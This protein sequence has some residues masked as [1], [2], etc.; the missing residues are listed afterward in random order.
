MRPEGSNSCLNESPYEKVG[1]WSRCS[2]LHGNAQGL[3]ESPYEKVGK[4]ISTHRHLNK[5]ATASMKVPTKK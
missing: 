3:N 2:L 4:Y 1:K 5:I